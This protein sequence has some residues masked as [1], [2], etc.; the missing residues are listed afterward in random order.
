MS[1]FVSPHT[2]ESWG[3]ASRGYAEFAPLM[4]GC[5]AEEIVERL[6]VQANAKVLEV[7]AGTGALTEAL[8]RR[9]GSVLAT[10]FAPAMIDVLEERM[11]A[12]GITNVTYAVMD[13]QALQLEDGA[14][15]RAACCFGMILFPDRVKGFSELR[16]VVRPGGRAAVTGW[17]GLERL[18]G[19]SIFLE[20]MR[21]A[22]PDLPP[23]AGPPALLS[24]ADPEKFEAEMRAGGFEDVEV[25]LVERTLEVPDFDEWW[26]MM[27]VGAPPVKVMFERIGEAGKGRLR[28]T[29]AGILE[30][31]FG[32]G[33]I[34]LNN[35]A[36]L[37]VGFVP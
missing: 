19:H 35:T 3:A 32:A 30:D 21:T 29:L 25:S 16:R 4:M 5:Y 1:N 11:E 9:A 26:R 24:L 17:G 36:T 13:G 37:G 2:P 34:R 23:P 22:F 14:F 20:G 33:P 10:D 28:D 7:A 15:D 12:A 18:E 31:R 6:D 27:T 8:A